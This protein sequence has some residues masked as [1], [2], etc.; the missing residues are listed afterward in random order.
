MHKR[1]NTF[2]VLVSILKHRHDD[3]VQP[4]FYFSIPANDVANAPPTELHFWSAYKKQGALACNA[5]DF[6]VGYAV[7]SIAAMNQI[8]VDTYFLII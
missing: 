3:I 4:C 1:V 6:Q 5:Q 8:T 7:R 2:A